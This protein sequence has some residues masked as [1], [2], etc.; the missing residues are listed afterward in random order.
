MNNILSIDIK[1]ALMVVVMGSMV[2]G[3]I[4]YAQNR[5]DFGRL[6][7]KEKTALLEV[8]EDTKRKLLDR[9]YMLRDEKFDPFLED[10]KSDPK[11]TAAINDVR[12]R[13]TQEIPSVAEELNLDLCYTIKKCLTDAPSNLD[14]VQAIY[15]TALHQAY[16]RAQKTADAYHAAAF[17]YVVKKAGAFTFQDQA[18]AIDDYRKL[19]DAR[20]KEIDKILPLIDAEIKRKVV[21]ARTQAQSGF[22]G[23]LFTEE[24][25][26][27]GLLK[28]KD[29]QEAQQ[30]RKYIT[31]SINKLKSQIK[32]IVL[33]FNNTKI[34]FNQIY[35][36]LAG[37]DL[38]VTS[39]DARIT[40]VNKELN[41]IQNAMEKTTQLLK[42]RHLKELKE[43]YKVDF[44]FVAQITQLEQLTNQLKEERKALRPDAKKIKLFR[45]ALEKGGDI[46]KPFQPPPLASL[47]QS[48]VS[49][50]KDRSAEEGSEEAAKKQLIEEYNKL[51][52]ALLK[53]QQ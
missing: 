10:Y 52:N 13:I 1:I 2:S 21:A 22:S 34:A 4:A 35:Q 25:F 12:K 44:D 9:I 8:A 16:E 47:P 37:D 11:V 30:A 42:D 53:Q 36:R 15:T 28:N 50:D 23:L 48:E 46:S 32:D 41:K 19:I 43:K 45:D 3:V 29:Y 14:A 5:D 27:A 51:K 40:S 18:K 17:A 24:K 20:Q 6:T 33:S 7:D 31:N 38:T 49:E 26:Q 39:F